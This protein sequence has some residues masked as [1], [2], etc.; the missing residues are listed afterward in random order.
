M[1]TNRRPMTVGQLPIQRLGIPTIY[2]AGRGPDSSVGPAA[3]PSIPRVYGQNPALGLVQRSEY[4][5]FNQQVNVSGGYEG[6]GRYIVNTRPVWNASGAATGGL[7][8]KS[9]LSN[10][11]FILDT[12]GFIANG[13]A[14]NV[15]D[16]FGS[17]WWQIENAVQAAPRSAG[18]SYQ[19]SVPIAPNLRRDA[20]LLVCASCPG[21]P[22]WPGLISTL[23]RDK[24][25][26]QRPLSSNGVSSR[27]TRTAGKGFGLTIGQLANS[28]FQALRP[29][30][31]LTPPLQDIGFPIQPSPYFQQVPATLPV[32]VPLAV[33]PA[34]LPIR[35]QGTIRRPVNLFRPL[36]PVSDATVSP[37][38]QGRGTYRIVASQGLNL[39]TAPN[40]S[41]QSHGVILPGTLV[42]VLADNSDDWVQ[43]TVNMDYRRQGLG[44]IPVT[45]YL[46]MSCVQAPGGPWLVKTRPAATVAGWPIG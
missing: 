13:S 21:A 2:P 3:T 30:V 6:P 27:L 43:A 12:V 1:W 44:F 7:E 22:I 40:S 8:V 41:A 25:I 4:G 28:R 9:V 11:D 23:Y 10:Q 20:I 32:P 39:R 26:I 19:N 24:S 33:P 15:I 14:V 34:R 31:T 29:A 42:E 37:G 45:G 36:V 35:Q 46:C 5:F 16:N 38:Y 17:G 18:Q